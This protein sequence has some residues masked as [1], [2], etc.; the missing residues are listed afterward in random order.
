MPSTRGCSARPWRCGCTADTQGRSVRQRV[1]APEVG[2]RSTP[3]HCDNLDHLRTSSD[4]P[5]AHRCPHRE[6]LTWN[7]GRL[8]LGACLVCGWETRQQ[9]AG[10]HSGAPLP[11]RGELCSEMRVWESEWHRAFFPRFQQRRLDKVRQRREEKAAERLEQELLRGSCSSSDC[12]GLGHR[13]LRGVRGW[14]SWLA[15][16]SGWRPRP[17][18]CSSAPPDTVH[19][20]EVA[21]QPPELTAR[22]RMSTS[23]GQVSRGGGRPAR[24]PG[25]PAPRPEDGVPHP[26]WA[27]GSW[28]SVGPLSFPLLPKPVPQ[29][30][31]LS[32]SLGRNR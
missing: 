22:P 25:R 28:T 32:F 27:Y 10:V 8:P 31:S 5:W 18:L 9:L 12:V 20:G 4:M 24:A 3:P 19:F 15:G 30:P 26:H 21:L 2:A 17:H 7:S 11:G 23:R 14:G 16:V 1:G 29:L 13:S 6:P